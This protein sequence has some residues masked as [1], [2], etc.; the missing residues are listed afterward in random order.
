MRTLFATWLQR[1]T[2]AR[3]ATRPP[4]DRGDVQT[5][6]LIR[7]R[8]SSPST[9]R[10][11]R[12]CLPSHC[13]AGAK[14]KKNC[15]VCVGER[16]ARKRVS[17][18]VHFCG[19]VIAAG[20]RFWVE[21]RSGSWGKRGAELHRQGGPPPCGDA[22]LAGVAVFAT[23]CHAQQPGGVVLLG[24]AALLIWPGWKGGTSFAVLGARPY[25]CD[26]TRRRPSDPP[27]TTNGGAPSPR[28]R[29]PL[30]PE[31]TKACERANPLAM[32]ARWPAGRKPAA[33]PPL[34]LPP[35]MESPPL[36]SPLTTSPPWQQKPRTMRWNLLPFR[37][38]GFL[39][40]LP[41]PFSP[42]QRQRK[43]SWGAGAAGSREGLLCI[44]LVLRT[45]GG[46]HLGPG[47]Y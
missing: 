15:V 1:G 3:N 14:V 22:H 35:Y 19:P 23:V 20:F 7:S 27:R 12:A 11:N 16:R 43:F 34:N 41:S 24:E 36:P 39:E 29:A 42:V 40:A 8:T 33:A 2:Y 13:G 9:T 10:P 17:I 45:C 32:E 46:A 47:Y 25:P 4:F 6:A 26:S 21:G 28:K 5:H 38:R 18:C 37:C 30:P 31:R 44:R